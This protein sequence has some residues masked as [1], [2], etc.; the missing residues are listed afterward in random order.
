MTPLCR[1]YKENRKIPF[2]KA[3]A[4]IGTIS[5]AAR[6][7]RI[8]RDAVHD[9]RRNDPSFERLFQMAKLRHAES[10]DVSLETAFSLFENIAHRVV[11]QHLWA[12]LSAEIA[13]G[14]VNLKKDLRD[15]GS[16]QSVS[17][18]NMAGFPLSLNRR[19]PGRFVDV[20]IPYCGNG[21]SASNL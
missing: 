21:N 10:I 5:G 1:A 18:G 13:I 17:S 4:R 7:V 8:S 3:L 12:R 11:P 14:C 6:T 16:K 2:L 15:G 19:L 20:A 9:W